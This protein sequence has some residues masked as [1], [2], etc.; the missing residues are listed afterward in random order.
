LIMNAVVDH[1][2]VAL[3]ITAS[4]VYAFARLAARPMKLRAL[5]ILSYLTQALPAIVGGPRV[6]DRIV[7]AAE[8][9]MLQSGCG[10]CG[11]CGA[12]ADKSAAQKEGHDA[13]QTAAD[14]K[15]RIDAASIGHRGHRPG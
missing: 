8:R 14:E 10:A 9:Q 3:A 13:G 11:S 12:D 1:L 6:R 4:A 7:R 2:L 5:S 15:E